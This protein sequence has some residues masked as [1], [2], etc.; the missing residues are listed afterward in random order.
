MD[1][2]TP[3]VIYLQTMKKETMKHEG[4]GRKEKLKLYLFEMDRLLNINKPKF[5][6]RI[7]VFFST[8]NFDTF[9]LP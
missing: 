8:Y 4:K 3:Q 7:P 5:L 1:L 6:A 2:G 9:S